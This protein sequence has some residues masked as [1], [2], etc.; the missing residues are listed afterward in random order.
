[1][2]QLKNLQELEVSGCYNIT[3]RGFAGL[4]CCKN[5]EIFRCDSAI[6]EEGKAVPLLLHFL[7]SNNKRLSELSLSN[8]AV[9]DIHFYHA[10][11]KSITCG[12]DKLVWED[13]NY[14]LE[15]QA[16]VINTEQSMIAE[17]GASTEGFLR[18]HDI[19]ELKSNDTVH[20]IPTVSTRK[21]PLLTNTFTV[22]NLTALDISYC[23]NLSNN[24]IKC[25]VALCPNVVKL[26]MR[27][28]DQQE[29][30]DE[31]ILAISNGMKQL[32]VLDIGGCL[33][34]TS[35]AFEYLG[36]NCADSLLELRVF[37]INNK[38][39]DFGK[40]CKLKKLNKI[41]AGNTS[42]VMANLYDLLQNCTFISEINIS[43]CRCINEVLVKQIRGELERRK[44]R[45]IIIQN[46]THYRKLPKKLSKAETHSR[47]KDL[48]LKC[49]DMNPKK[50]K[51]SKSG[52]KKKGSKKKKKK[53]K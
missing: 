21:N 14:L 29:I 19:H 16:K 18:S 38:N 4:R 41:D 20:M 27:C 17:T 10:Y 34:L 24:G 26:C 30:N 52:S 53:K 45:V 23:K 32:E 12:V 6:I 42:I 33:N 47:I 9:H 28:L 51:S 5:L 15:D 48:Y 8:C 13:F 49:K 3:Q 40:L 39:I 31:A 50:N 22:Q 1:M 25:L 36:K 2:C 44:R 43:Y 46:V 7:M 11:P 37:G 35:A